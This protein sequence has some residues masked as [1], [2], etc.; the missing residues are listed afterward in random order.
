[1]EH[2]RIDSCPIPNDAK[3]IYINEAYLADKSL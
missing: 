1:M 2:H 3:A